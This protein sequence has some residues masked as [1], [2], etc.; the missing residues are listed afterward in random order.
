MSDE[1]SRSTF[2]EQGQRF[3]FCNSQ[4][5]RMKKA[6]G[7]G[8][9]VSDPEAGVHAHGLDRESGKSLNDGPHIHLFVLEDG[10]ALVTE[11]DGVHEHELDPSGDHTKKDG[12]HKHTVVL[13]DGTRLVTGDGLSAHDH[14]LLVDFTAFDGTHDHSLVLPDGSELKSLSAGEF[15]RQ[16]PRPSQGSPGGATR[17]LAGEKVTSSKRSNERIV[18]LRVQGEGDLEGLI[19]H[20]GKTAAIG[21]SFPV[22]VDPKDSEFSK[23]FSFDGDGPFRVN[24]E[25]VKPVKAEKIDGNHA[26]NLTLDAEGQESF[27]RLS[28]TL[29]PL[30]DRLTSYDVNL[31][32]AAS[33]LAADIVVV[34]AHKADPSFSTV[35]V[36][37]AVVAGQINDGEV[38]DRVS[39]LLGDMLAQGAFAVPQSENVG[40]DGYSG[41]VSKTA[42][43]NEVEFQV[44]KQEDE[45]R[46]VLGI[47]L[48]P[49]E[50]DAQEDIYSEDE[51]TQ[52]AWR[53][54]ERYQQFGLMHKEILQSILP[55]ESFIAPVDFEIDGQFVKKGTW[56]L[57]VR[58]L[59]DEI[60][61]D[62][63]S[64][65]LTGFSIGGSAL[66]RIESV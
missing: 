20:I 17:I 57:R 61:Q 43:L 15:A 3:A 37:L 33:D 25:S 51:I 7:L 35:L 31:A 32:N 18:T 12:K 19:D 58:V 2:P 23:T 45:Q 30:A 28:S 59:D 21:H 42:E 65:R 63:R 46:T 54:M 38:R 40:G 16:H 53:F 22:V 27:L 56:L 44:L 36:D 9:P 62:V 52:T 29:R 11:E 13:P 66:R 48:E 10:T 49:E 50:I 5:D 1:E 4:F 8:L 64:G 39:K 34:P 47:V 14:D 24:K 26:I 6:A 41:G 60:W 55:L